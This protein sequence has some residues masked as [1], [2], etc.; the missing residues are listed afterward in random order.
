[1]GYLT[2]LQVGWVLGQYQ[3]RL[4]V[5][6]LWNALQNASEVPQ[7]RLLQYEPEEP[8]PND[9]EAPDAGTADESDESDSESEEAPDQFFTPSSFT[10]PSPLAASPCACATTDAP[11]GAPVGLRL[12]TFHLPPPAKSSPVAWSQETAGVAAA[13]GVATET[14]EA[15]EAEKPAVAATESDACA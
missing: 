10:R 9:A 7:A 11:Q 8:E 15:G 4:L 13:A 3:F 1:M 5:R 2:S 14:G 12:W 6:R